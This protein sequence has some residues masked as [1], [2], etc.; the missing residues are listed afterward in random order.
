MSTHNMIH[1]RMCAP[2]TIQ[3]T[4]NSVATAS[5]RITTTY[6][7][8]VVSLPF[9]CRSGNRHG[10]ARIAGSRRLSGQWEG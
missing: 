10:P 5:R 2:W 6:V 1:G 4:I 9:G 7:R 8:A 3:A